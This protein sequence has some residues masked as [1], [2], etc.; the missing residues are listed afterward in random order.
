MQNKKRM[1]PKLKAGSLKLKV[2]ALSAEAIFELLKHIG[3]KYQQRY[4]SRLISSGDGG[5]HL[6]SELDPNGGEAGR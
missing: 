2:E 4:I 3:E 6:Y 1:A 5:F